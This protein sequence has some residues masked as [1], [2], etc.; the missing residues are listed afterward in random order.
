MAL[1]E[2][3]RTR[4]EPQDLAF[5]HLAIDTCPIV[6]NH[7]H[8]LLKNE[9]MGKHP[10]LSTA[11]EAHGDALEDSRYSLAH[12]RAVNILA[13]HLGCERSWDAVAEAIAQK[14]ATDADAW[15]R[16]CLNGIET[17]LLDDGLNASDEVESYSW[18][19]S[20]VPSRCKRIVRIEAVAEDLIAH[21]CRSA[22]TDRRDLNLEDAIIADIR[23]TLE[24]FLDD[25]EVVGFK[26]VICYRGGLDIPPSDNASEA[27]ARDTLSTLIDNHLSG[28]NDFIKNKRLQ[29]PV[30][31]HYLVHLIAKLITE[32]PAQLKKPIQFHTGLGDNDIGIRPV[33]SCYIV[34]IHMLTYVITL[35]KSS[36]SHMQTFIREYPSVPIVILHASYPWT[37]EAGYLAAMYKN[38]YADIGEVFPFLSQHGQESVIRQIFELC[39]WSKILWSTDGHWFPETYLVSTVQIRSVLKT[40]IGELVSTCQISGKQAYDLVNAILFTNSKKLYNLTSLLRETPTYEQAWQEF[41]ANEASRRLR[42]E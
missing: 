16:V 15:I 41:T 7:A 6:D 33:L 22:K 9:F 5:I 39:P 28:A 3:D 29:H 19:D 25:P 31:N 35:I 13:N 34:E 21:Y 12:I 11:S 1:F 38:V 37:R 23:G 2:Q 26:S 27:A 36:P 17:I 32:H 30:I 20:F 4:Q 40:V 8:P 18:H 24:R 42:A 14:R 10:L